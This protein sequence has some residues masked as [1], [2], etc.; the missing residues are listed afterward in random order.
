M[1]TTLNAMQPGVGHDGTL[2]AADV[3]ALDR[4]TAFAATLDLDRHP[5]AGD[6]LPPLWHWLYFWSVAR[7]S[8]LGHDGHPLKGVFLP[9]L[10]LPRRMWA[11]GRVVFENPLPIGETAVRTS[12]VLS[13]EHKEGRSGPLGFVTVEHLIESGGT[14]AIREEHDIVYRGAVEPGAAAPAPKAAPDGA[15]WQRDVTPDEVQLFR[16]SALTFNGHRIHYDR[17]YAREIEGYPDLV[18]HGP[19]ISTLL[20]DL[21]PRALPGATV[22]EYAYRAVRPTFLG[23][24]FSVCGRVAEDGKTIDLWAK[25]HDGWMTMSARA[26]LA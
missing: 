14:V 22:R 12:R 19:L 6:A 13:V 23:N 20:L 11:G 21:V 9:D 10:G 26:T 7:Q 24:T 15:Q 8:E 5:V 2:I 17:T 18:V 16:Y 1:E 3:I 4:A 25:D